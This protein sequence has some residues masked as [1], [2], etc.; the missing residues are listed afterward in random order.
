M[1]RSD[2]SSDRFLAPV[3]N[4]RVDAGSLPLVSIVTPSLNMARYLREAIDSVLSQDYPNI[5]H[6]VM[7]GGSTDGTVEILESYGSRLRYSIGPD[8][9]AADAINRG[10]RE[11]RG[12][13]LA[14]LSADDRYYP[15]AVRLAVERLM[16]A[17]E[18]C[19]VYGEAHWI[20]AA[21]DVIRPYPT[22]PLDL[23]RLGKECCICQP[24][25]FFR[26]SAFEAV[27]GLDPALQSAF[28]Y[29]L[30][31]RMARKY[32]FRHLPAL[33]A[34]SRMHPANKTMGQRGQ[35]FEESIRV[36]RRHYHYV[37]MAWI[38]ADLCCRTNRRDPFP[39]PLPLFPREFL[40]SLPVGCWHNRRALV[41]YVS[42]WTGT[43]M[44][45]ASNLVRR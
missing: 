30:W 5:E 41:Q 12:S 14:W 3:G 34:A 43:L 37:P 20:D 45:A 11:G 26:R 29:D 4:G 8:G 1:N 19:A 40:L 7:D 25:C 23:N 38:H 35:V 10:F 31:I 36:L 24:A 22:Q 27:G 16:A 9:G 17:P 42:E 18:A 32:P 44:R 39:E 2:S 21:G 28:D 33:L 6:I 15:G 13:I